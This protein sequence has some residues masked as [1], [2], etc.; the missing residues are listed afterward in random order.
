LFDVPATLAPGAGDHLVDLKGPL[1]TAS[2]LSENLLLE[3]TEG[4][5]KVNVG[6][7]CVG[8]P[9]LESLMSLHA[10]ATDFSQRTPEIARAQAWL[11]LDR[12]RASLE[13]AA[14]GK[15]VPGA[16]GR[17]TDRAL[18]LVGHDTN[19][20]NVAGLLNLTWIVDGRRDDTP[21]G[22]A[23]V[24]EL[25]RSRA[26]GAYS[27]RAFYTAQT[28]DEMRAATPLDMGSNSPARA[29]LFIPGCSRDDMSCE[30]GPFL[31]L[32]AGVSKPQ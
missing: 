7:G 2:T 27:V 17:P 13:Q 22:G 15:A 1:Y 30:L 5:E 9:E 12:V 23:L 31:R 29:A 25:W 4:M 20:E 18:F 28:L 14:D 19:Q 3:Y 16:F 32:L 21:P 24:F 10:A 11:L 26:T 6:W 8:R